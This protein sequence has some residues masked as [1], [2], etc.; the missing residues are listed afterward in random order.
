M[1]KQAQTGKATDY[2][3]NNG[4]FILDKDYAEIQD[5]TDPKDVT[6]PFRPHPDCLRFYKY[7]PEAFALQ[8]RTHKPIRDSKKAKP[9]RMIATV[10]VTIDELR[11]MLA[12]AE[13]HE[14]EAQ[15]RKRERAREAARAKAVCTQDGHLVTIP[16]PERDID[17]EIE[18][19]E[20]IE[21]D[22]R[23]EA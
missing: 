13:A 8:I 17:A 7:S 14:A 3:R 12:Y 1:E 23:G 6:Q 9:R 11:D 20:A 18:E 21:R 5:I 15:A 22:L 10:R 4:E 2:Y 16:E 19:I